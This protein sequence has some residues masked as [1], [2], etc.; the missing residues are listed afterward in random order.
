MSRYRYRTT[1]TYRHHKTSRYTHNVTFKYRYNTISRYRD[2]TSTYKHHKTSRH[3]HDT[4]CSDVFY[5]I[6]LDISTTIQF[7]CIKLDTSYI[8]NS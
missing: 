4:Q 3:R 5:D 7:K 8:T 6:H 1:L 2:Q